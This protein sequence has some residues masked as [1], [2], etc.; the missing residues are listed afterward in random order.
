MTL[1]FAFFLGFGSAMAEPALNT[2][3][4][5]VEDLS[6]GSITSKTLVYAVA[7]GVG[8]GFFIG[9]SQI[10]WQRPFFHDF[11]LIY[12]VAIFLTVISREEFV[13]VAWD[14]GVVTTGP[15]TVPLILSLGLGFSQSLG[16]SSAFGMVALTSLCPVI[17]VL[18]TGLYSSRNRVL[19][20]GA[21]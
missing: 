2:L 4:R 7:V 12:C 15:V 9:M 10:L 8:I 16:S 21:K 19:K 3:G 17:S 6:T 13:Q 18:A 11:A 5:T 20:E 14:S 1:A